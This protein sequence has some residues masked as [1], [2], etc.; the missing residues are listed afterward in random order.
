M[1]LEYKISFKNGIASTDI[2]GDGVVFLSEGGG[3]S[4][5]EAREWARQI[6]E[7][8]RAGMDSPLLDT[9]TAGALHLY[10][11]LLRFGRRVN[12]NVESAANQLIDLGLA[13]YVWN[14]GRK[15]IW[16]K[17]ESERLSESD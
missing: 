16:L 12:Y 8:V 7:R 3:P 14:E 4:E 2:S 10:C 13:E 17:E 5:R 11:Q 1:K 9:V 15:E 6:I